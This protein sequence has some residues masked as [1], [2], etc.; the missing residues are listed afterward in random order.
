MKKKE[1]H[2]K[3]IDALKSENIKLTPQR[4]AVFTNIMD[5]DG[6]RECDDIYNSLLKSGITVSKATIYRTLDILVEYNLARKL[7][8]GD[9][10]AKYEKKIGKPHHDHM[11]CIETGDI[12][13]FDN[14][15][16]EKLQEQEAEKRGYEIIKHVHQLFVRPIKKK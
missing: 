6:H 7:V 15:Q 1:I 10:K 4:E 11:I 13:E 12:I 8:I 16:I 14:D 5:S 9:G 2:Q 3:F